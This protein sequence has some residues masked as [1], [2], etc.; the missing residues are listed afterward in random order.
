M[1]SC[2]CSFNPSRSTQ[3]QYGYTL[4]VHVDTL[5]CLHRK[6]LKTAM[7]G[8]I[9]GDGIHVPSSATHCRA[10]LP[11]A[12]H[13]GVT[14]S[15]LRHPR[16]SDC[17]TLQCAASHCNVLQHDVV[18]TRRV[19]TSRAWKLPHTTARHCSKTLQQ[20]TAAR[21]CKTLFDCVV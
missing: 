15:L 11:A 19:M 4:C 7:F 3:V 1:R 16:S 2:W 10:L 9:P 12:T 14:G 5:L 8:S 20:D 6:H 21:H 18:T 17:N 13:C